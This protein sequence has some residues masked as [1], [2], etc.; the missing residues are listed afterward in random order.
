[1]ELE[2][3]VSQSDPQPPF[4]AQPQSQPG[5]TDLMEPRP[6][7]G[8]RATRAQAAAG[9]EGGHHRRRQRHRARG[10]HRLRA[11]GC[12]RPDQL[13]PE[14][15]EDAQQVRSE[16]EAAG[17]KALLVPGDISSADH[18]RSIIARAV[19]EFGRVDILVNNAA[20]QNTFNSIDE[21]SDEE[22]EHT[23]AVNIHAMFY[24]TKAAVPHMKPG[25][26]IINTTSVQADDPSQELLA[27]AS[28]KGAIQNFTGG[29]AQM[30]AEKG[31][32]AN[33]VA[34]GPIWTPLIPATM[35]RRRSR[36]SASRCR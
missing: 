30:L 29:L 12:R 1:L 18:C 14:E 23:F 24:L 17:R 5:M 19:E 27:Y 33:C 26:A 8:E 35:P 28:T 31:I 22:W 2:Q 32:R 9:Q 15:E 4:M 16:V 25:A 13:P 10:R 34:P 7:H 20:Y 6:D 3:S 36:A 21:L 11:R